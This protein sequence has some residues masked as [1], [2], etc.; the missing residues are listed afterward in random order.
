MADNKPVD[1]ID[2]LLSKDEET[3]TVPTTGKELDL[4]ETQK[5]AEEMEWSKLS[6][7]TQDRV[8]QLI[9]ER[10]ELRTNRVSPTITTTAPPPPP[11]LGPNNLTAQQKL[12]ALEALRSIGGVTQEDLQSY[13]DRLVLDTEY[14]RLENSYNGTNGL[15]KFD[16]SEIEDHMKQS[17][18][19]NPE[20]A[21]KDLYEDE[22]I[23]W[24]SRQI[25]GK[26]KTYSEKPS[27]TGVSPREVLTPDMINERISKPDGR[28]WYEKNRDKIKT[29][30]PE[31]SRID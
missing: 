28:A 15:P 13:K 22:Y 8:R 9:K 12:E 3:P 29:L 26:G 6:G 5:S 16:R 14:S 1:E 27:T 10:N 11:N 24:K 4:G 21:F 30:L 7:S 19:Y 31:L 2:A 25:S 20:K 18:I 23:D 17:G